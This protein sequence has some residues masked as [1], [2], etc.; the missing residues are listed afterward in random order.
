MI[1]ETILCLLRTGCGDSPLKRYGHELDIIVNW[2]PDIRIGEPLKKVFSKV[3]RY[4]FGKSYVESGVLKTNNQIV[5]LVRAEH[6][7]YMLWPS[8]MYE[9]QES[10]FQAIRKEG[11]LVIG[12]FFDDECRFD[13]YS[14][15]WI[16]YLDYVLTVDKESVKK[17]Q[18]Q[19]A[20]A[21]HLL[22]TSNPEVFRRL[23]VEK[24]YDVSFVG[25]KIAD[26]GSLVDQLGA[27]NIQ[28]QT[29]GKGWS[30]G[31]VSLDEMVN[32]YNATKINLCFVKSYAANTRPQ[33][34]DKI[35]QI[36]MCG[37][38]LLCEYIPGIEEFYEVDK[39]IVCFRDIEEAT[40]KIRYYLNHEAEREAIAQA[41]WERVQRDHDQVIVLLRIFEE[42]EKDTRSGKRRVI[43]HP[44]QLD[45]P[46]HIRR[47]P[48]SYHLRWAKVLMM[49][50]YD[51]YR[52]QEELDLALFYDPEN[53]GA[54][55]LSMIGRF[56]AFVRPG[57]IRLWTVL[58]RLKQAL[59][60]RLA[61]ILLQ[62]IS[63]RASL[64]QKG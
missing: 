50:G 35:F 16:S 15:W 1:D 29:F 7:K 42:I 58:G 52:W 12:W 6:P 48:S 28:V 57:L 23:D 3:L 18:E 47:L 33:M 39:E 44:G 32:I 21:M 53:K 2:D 17:Y 55:R 63:V 10:T 37:G 38:F 41:G 22:V 56:P 9:I 19:G 34:K 43:D 8:S 30:S 45:M 36:C 40:A 59:R 64:A 46:W 51:K 49:E 31:H 60:S 13:D 27:D 62:I 26:R 24:R 61:A 4:D 54:R 14:R 5:D 20:T 25:S 11:T